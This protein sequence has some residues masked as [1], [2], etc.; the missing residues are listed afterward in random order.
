MKK[1]NVYKEAGKIRI[2]AMIIHGDRDEIVPIE[3]SRKLV[4]KIKGSELVVAKGMDHLFLG[5]GREEF[6]R[7]AAEWMGEKLA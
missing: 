5:K 2:P 7:K 3:Q 6:G 4:G 1:Y